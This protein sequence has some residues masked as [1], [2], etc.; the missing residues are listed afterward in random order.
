MSSKAENVET[1]LAD[2]HAMDT[3]ALR[4]RWKDTFKHPAPMRTSGEL[5]IR[6]LA[7]Q[8]QAQAYGGLRPATLR[9][10]KRLAADL[11]A[12]CGPSKANVPSLS[13]GVQLMREWNGETHVVEVL[14]EGFAWKEQCY[15]SLSAVARAVTGVRWSGPRFFGLTEARESASAQDGR[16]RPRNAQ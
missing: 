5:M 15:P 2:L 8:I 14:T 4:A 11:R 6:A 10:L 3:T 7:Y 9:R 16:G 13:P 12:G 1:Q